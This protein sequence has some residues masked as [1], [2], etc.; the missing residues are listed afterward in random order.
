MAV[1]LTDLGRRVLAHLPIWV[2][3]EDAHVALEGGPENSI[4]SYTLPDFTARLAEDPFTPPMDEE[5]VLTALEGLKAA[6]LASASGGKWRM[7]KRGHA[8]LTAAPEPADQEPGAVV[9]D[10]APARGV[11]A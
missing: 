9:I 4:R 8:A 7:L 6:G 2:E 10:V 3:D 11:S 1:Q 5:Q